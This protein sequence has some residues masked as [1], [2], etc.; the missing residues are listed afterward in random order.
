MTPSQLTPPTKCEDCLWHSKNESDIIND[1]ENP[2]CYCDADV[3]SFS[4]YLKKQ[5]ILGHKVVGNDCQHFCSILGGFSG[6]S[7]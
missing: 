6:K 4:D 7:T 1:V 2:R 5:H 3:I